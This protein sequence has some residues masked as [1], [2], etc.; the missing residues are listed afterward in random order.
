LLDGFC[1]HRKN[2]RGAIH[3]KLV[4]ETK[5]AKAKKISA[6]VEYDSWRL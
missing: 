6:N 4:E 1:V 3:K 5:R 2:S